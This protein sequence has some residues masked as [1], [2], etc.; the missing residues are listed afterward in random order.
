M[1]IIVRDWV[2]DRMRDDNHSSELATGFGMGLW[3]R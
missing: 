2:R 3:V 1:I